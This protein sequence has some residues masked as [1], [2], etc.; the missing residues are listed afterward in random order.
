MLDVMSAFEEPVWRRRFGD[1][2]ARPDEAI[3]L[4]EAALLVACEEYPELDVEAY[5]ARL[6]ELGRE[7][8]RRA[9]GLTP[10][11]SVRVVKRLLF[12][13]LGFS[14]N[15]QHYYDPRNSFLNDV[16]DRRTGIPITLATVFLEVSRRAGLETHGVGLPG[17]FIVRV[18]LP[19]GPWLLDPF[20]GGMRLSLDD[21]QRRVDRIFEGKLRMEPDM[22]AP[23][24]PRAMLTRMLQNL[25]AIYVRAQD[26]VRALGV[27]ELLLRVTPASADELRD[28]GLIYAA[29]DCYGLAVR[30]LGD[31]VARVPRSE[32]T[33]DL[34]EKIA[35]LRAKAARV[36]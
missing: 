2:L 29:L 33:D 28:R 1:L 30:D 35:T 8:R 20:H 16:L 5:R 24:G 9:A 15:E 18:E 11:E 4:A 36:N 23:C 25:K 7:A 31:Y 26:F 12:V 21:C 19:D 17:H 34:R 3:D 10:A 6:D 22:L 32:E 27:V 13:E 14:G